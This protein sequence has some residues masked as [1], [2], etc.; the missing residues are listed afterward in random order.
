VAGAI[1]VTVSERRSQLRNREIALDGLGDLV[2][3]A[4]EPRAPLRRETRP[5]RGSARRHLV[6]K[7]LRSQI[8]QQRQRPSEE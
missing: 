7:K 8:K 4:L 3:A 2:R 5:T 1:T 6:A